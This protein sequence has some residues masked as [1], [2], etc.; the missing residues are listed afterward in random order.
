MTAYYYMQLSPFIYS[1]YGCICS[2]SSPK[3]LHTQTA[4]CVAFFRYPD[5]RDGSRNRVGF[6]VLKRWEVAVHLQRSHQDTL[7]APFNVFLGLHCIKD[8]VTASNS[9]QFNFQKI[10]CRI[11]IIHYTL[12]ISRICTLS[13]I[14]FVM[15]CFCHK[16]LL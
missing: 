7:L 4:L 9:R 15:V 3:F 12:G 14:L 13:M 5:S 1:E 16:V 8:L 6:T 2:E 11:V 10:D